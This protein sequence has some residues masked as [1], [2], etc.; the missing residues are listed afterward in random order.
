MKKHTLTLFGLLCLLF[1]TIGSAS[2]TVLKLTFEGSLAR[3]YDPSNLTPFPEPPLGTAF[4]FSFFVDTSTTAMTPGVASSTNVTDIQFRFAGE[5]F[6]SDSQQLV[7]TNDYYAP[8][9]LFAAYRDMWIVQ[10]VDFTTN[11]SFGVVLLTDFD[12]PPGGPISDVDFFIPDPADWEAGGAFYNVTDNS[13]VLAN[14]GF[15]IESVTVS[16]VPVP[17]AAWFFGS[18]ILAT[19]ALRRERRRN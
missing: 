8:P 13:S 19:I 15:D 5:Y 10:V 17:A 16:P 3:Y 6:S 2:A 12:T 4:E 9:G 7:I 18:A 14:V 1:A 11:H